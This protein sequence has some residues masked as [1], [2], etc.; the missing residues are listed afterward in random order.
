MLSLQNA[1][2]VKNEFRNLADY[3]AI[4]MPY[5]VLTLNSNPNIFDLYRRLR[6]PIF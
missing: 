5:A 4:I 3:N 6:D 1:K 2:I